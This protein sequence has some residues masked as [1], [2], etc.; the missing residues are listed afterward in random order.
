M[1]FLDTKKRYKKQENWNK[2]V[3]RIEKK[4]AFNAESIL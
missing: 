2:Y 1:L 4:K 3:R